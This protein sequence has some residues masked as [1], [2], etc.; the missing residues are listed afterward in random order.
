MKLNFGI[1][2]ILLFALNVAAQTS[3]KSV[4]KRGGVK[5]AIRVV[6]MSDLASPDV[7]V[8]PD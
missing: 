8:E 3:R 2:L 5:K 1:V 7:C 4:G 6:E